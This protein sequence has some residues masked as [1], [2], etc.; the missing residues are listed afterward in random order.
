[1]DL[2]VPQD[3]GLVADAVRYCNRAGRVD[4]PAWR[5]RHRSLS[6]RLVESSVYAKVCPVNSFDLTGTGVFMIC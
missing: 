1:V 5:Q 6:G 2:Q 4:A 3:P